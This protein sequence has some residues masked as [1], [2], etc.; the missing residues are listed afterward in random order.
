[1]Y[2][3][4]WVRWETTTGK[5]S[6]EGKRRGIPTAYCAAHG[7]KATGF[8]GAHLGPEQGSLWSP[9]LFVNIG[10]SY[11]LLVESRKKINAVLT[12]S[13]YCNVLTQP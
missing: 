12:G 13:G 10:K 11:M 2:I 8:Q 5:E 1:M 9:D 6:R 4:L 7:E 3:G